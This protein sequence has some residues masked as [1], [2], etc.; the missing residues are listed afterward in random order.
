MLAVTAADSFYDSYVTLQYRYKAAQKELDAFK[1]GSRY[2]KLQ[3][4]Y[5]RVDAGYKKEIGRLTLELAAA[6]A[7]TKKVGDFWYNE[8]STDWDQYLKELARK[9]K[10]ILRLNDKYWA[11]LRESDAKLD[12]VIQEYEGQLAEK[13]AIIEA[14]KAELAHKDALL[15]RDSTNTNLPTSQTP[16]G[17]EKQIPNSRRGSGKNKG[18]QPGHKKHALKTPAEDEINECKEHK[19]GEDEVCP[20]CGSNDFSYTGEYEDKYEYDVK[21]N[22]IKRR[23]RYWLAI[24]NTCGET[25]KTGQGPNLKADAQYGANVDALSLSLM[26]TTNAAI[27][28][29]PMFLS[30]LTG[31]EICP[32]EAYMVKLQR[33]SAQNLGQFRQDLRR[34]MI[35]RDLLYWDDTVIWADK[36][37]ICLRFYGDEDIA[38]YVAHEKKDLNGIME[39]DILTVLQATTKVMH[40]HNTV[41]YNPLFAFINLECNAHLQRDLQKIV[42][43][44][45]HMVLL[46]IKNL[47]SLTIKD[48]NDLKQAEATAFDDA[49]IEA[50]NN[51]LTA[52]LAQAETLAKENTSRYTGSQERALVARIIKYRENFFAW[53][54][55]FSLPTTNNLSERGLRGVKTKMKVSGQFASVETADYYAIVRT[56]IETCRRNGI[57]EMEALIRLCKGNPYTVAEIFS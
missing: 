14:L 5:R 3:E 15:G 9:D 13:D 22:V 54:Y 47:I 16:P 37:R 4:D 53:V 21:I 26:N 28:K 45:G 31:E 40:D 7:E 34:L 43:E 33:R 50:F 1:N 44:T 6:R 12:S 30:G 52:L 20:T 39:D 11:L 10:E 46:E 24:C 18:G 29:V 57:N 42:D 23:H 19:L 51:N 25:V 2:K 27:N 48:R 32:S 38:Y 35:E 8:R 36:A 17:K 49:Y 56:Y 55:D 41:N